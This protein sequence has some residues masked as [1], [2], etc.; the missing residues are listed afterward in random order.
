MVTIKK[1]TITIDTTKADSSKG[2]TDNSSIPCPITEWTSLSE[3]EKAV[4][5][6]V[7]IPEK[8]S[9]LNVKTYAD[10]SG[11]L[12]EIFYTYGSDEI[13]YRM[14]KGTED[15]SGDYSV[16]NTT[17][18]VT[19]GDNSITIY[20]NDGRYYLAKWSDASYS[21]SSTWDSQELKRQSCLPILHLQTKACA[22]I[23]ERNSNIYDRNAMR[24][25]VY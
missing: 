11:N 21:Y 23:D 22:Y 25:Y 19:V 8:L 18:K 24:G 9:S 2:S 10:I 12:A 14:S 1:N 7:V 15:N 17:E 5:F 3:L 20:G 6:T 4:G 16:Y 13:L